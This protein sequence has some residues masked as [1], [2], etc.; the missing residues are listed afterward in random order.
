MERTLWPKRKKNLDAKEKELKAS[1]AKVEAGLSK[2][3]AQRK[4]FEANK[5][6]M[7]PEQ[8]AQTEA[9]LLPQKSS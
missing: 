3:A 2:V 6:Y 1:K 5:Q 9:K 8:I 7:T 4:D